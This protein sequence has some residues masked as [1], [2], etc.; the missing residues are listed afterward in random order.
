[1]LL[2]CCV[3]GCFMSADAVSLHGCYCA[4]VVI[5]VGVAALL[6]C[7]TVVL[8]DV[9]GVAGCFMGAA[10][11]SCILYYCTVMLVSVRTC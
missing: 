8:Q 5:P 3:T 7:Y 11:V 9:R 4:V 1:M 6:C 2:H 10:V